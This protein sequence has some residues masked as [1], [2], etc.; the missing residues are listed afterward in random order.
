MDSNGISRRQLIAGAAVATVSVAAWPRLLLAQTQ[1]A[2]ED[3][4][5]VE[6]LMREHGVLR[7]LLLIFER[8]SL[9]LNGQEPLPPEALPQS[10]ELVRKFIQEYHEKLEE[11]HVFPAFERAGQMADLTK[12]L[13]QQH[14]QGRKLIAAL[15]AISTP[16][17]L[18]DSDVREKANNYLH[19]F[20]RMYR[21]HAA[22]E[23]T[24]LFPAFRSVLK[25]GQYQK[26]GDEFEG[27]ETR[28]FGHEGFEKVVE[29][30]AEL[31]K[32]L[33]IYELS[34]FTTLV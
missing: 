28:L 26:L 7:R 16:K 15:V 9:L 25:A 33:Q 18:F 29:Q 34:E 4:L 14:E 13:R 8:V 10:L 12:V 32:K 27:Q 19:A 20:E 31:E 24:V 5:P 1:P 3:V 30:V 11:E 23:D 17:A 21:P 22:R 2:P 6:D